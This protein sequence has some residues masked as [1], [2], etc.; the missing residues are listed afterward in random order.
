MEGTAAHQLTGHMMKVQRE[1]C[2]A[3]MRVWEELLPQLRDRGV[4]L[5]VDEGN[6]AMSLTEVRRGPVR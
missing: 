6:M 2:V 4:T 3:L 5:R 1:R